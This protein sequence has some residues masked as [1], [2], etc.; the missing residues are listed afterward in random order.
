M[1]SSAHGHADEPDRD[2]SSGSVTRL[3]D[4]GK[5]SCISAEIDL[6]IPVVIVRHGAR[7]IREVLGA[8][9]TS[10]IHERVVRLIT[11]SEPAVPIVAPLASRPQLPRQSLTTRPLLTTTVVVVTVE[12]AALVAREL[13]C[14]TSSE[15]ALPRRW[16]LDVEAVVSGDI[17]PDV[18]GLNYHALANEV[19]VRAAPI[20]VPLSGE[21]QFKALPAIGVAR[22]TMTA[23]HC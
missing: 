11:L 5:Q 14:A 2:S 15:D 22:Q 4:C 7:D 20:P 23:T 3:R 17:A 21:S 10:E 18:R 13:Y 19:W 12:I 8:P 6:W 1:H 9:N 16:N